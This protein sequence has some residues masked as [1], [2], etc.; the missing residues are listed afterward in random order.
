M[1]RR[2]VSFLAISLLILIGSIYLDALLH[3]PKPNAQNPAAQN[4]KAGDGKLVAKAAGEKPSESKNSEKKPA[5]IA[6]ANSEGPK[7]AIAAAP[8]GPAPAEEA[9]E[10]KPQ[11]FTLG[12]LTPAADGGKYQMLATLTNRGA[13]IERIEFSNPKY[14]DLDNRHGYLGRLGLQPPAKGTGCLVHV[15][16]DGTPAA[17]AGMKPGDQ[18]TAVN[19]QA[20]DSPEQLLTVLDTTDPGQQVQ[21]TIVRGGAKQDLTA[22]LG[23]YPLSVISPE[24][25]TDP[26][27][28]VSPGSHDPFSFLFTLHRAD[29]DVNDTAQLNGEIAGLHLRDGLWQVKRIDDNTVEF[30]RKLPKWELE[31]VKRYTL[32]QVEKNPNTPPAP[33]YHLM[34]QVEVRNIGKKQHQVAYQLDGPTGMPTEGWW[35]SYRIFSQWGSFALRDVALKFHG[36]ELVSD[37]AML[38]A[39]RI[40]KELEAK[41]N[42]QP[43]PD[44]EASKKYGKYGPELAETPLA[45]IGVD[46]QYFAG[47]LIPQNEPQRGQKFSPWFADVRT[48]IV[49]KVPTDKSVERKVDCTSRLTSVDTLL[50]PGKKLEHDYQIFVG[51]KQPVLL[52]QYG[53]SPGN[54]LEPLVYYGW[55]GWVAAP[56]VAVLELFHSIV[57]NY[58]ISILMLTILVRLCMFP[59][60]RKQALSAKKMQELQPEM[61]KINEKY[62]ANAEQRTKAMQ[63]LWRKHNYNPMGGCLLVFVQLPIFMGL[64][65][66]LGVNVELRQASLLGQA[67]H[68]C[69]NLAAPDMLWKWD[70][71]VPTF[72]SAPTAWLGPY[73]NLLPILTVGLFVWQQSMFMPPSTDENSA[74]QQKIMKLMTLAMGFL[75]FK[76]ASGLCLYF[77]ASSAWGIAERKLLPKTIA[78]AGA[79]GADSAG[80]ST[81]ATSSNGESRGKS[82]SKKKQRGRRS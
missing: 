54:T 5:A 4:E 39:D 11:W 29:D 38:V 62:K 35:Y 7:A 55:F 21:I 30:T 49:G 74:M 8:G 69:S 76:V 59:L 58:G 47:M 64:Y 56:M 50:D 34:L 79:P 81:P 77:I 57:G 51:P 67:V 16:G 73:F 75:Y 43:P 48:L 10:V 31:L 1:E 27:D 72:L 17:K 14:G 22:T 82:S 80:R 42:G 3:P 36:H 28:I 24:L 6:A 68:W 18:V 25:D 44:D 13:A 20:I 70:H 78:T 2:L 60:S 33:A 23:R 52:D 40:Q 63:E 65:R 71:V 46:A 66:S 37:N 19:G 61:K 32:A 53:S 45:Y 41:Q 15:V 9:V 12:S 26:L